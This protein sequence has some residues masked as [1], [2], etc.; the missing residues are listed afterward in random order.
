MNFRFKT[1]NGTGLY[2][3]ENCGNKI[4]S[5]ENF[6]QMLVMAPV[7]IN[8]RELGVFRLGIPIGS[9]KIPGIRTYTVLIYCIIGS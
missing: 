3:E 9:V 4:E 8:I 5:W 1:G 2:I 6:F 7:N